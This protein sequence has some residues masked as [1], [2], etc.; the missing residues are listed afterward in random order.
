MK[1]KFRLKRNKLYIFPLSDLHLG[2]PNCDLDYFKYWCEVFEGTRTKHKII[3]L[4]GDLIDMQSLR[5]G[6]FEQNLSA[7]EQ[8]SKL[9]DLLEPY[10]KYINYMTIGNHGRRPK[11]DYNLDVGKLV[12][13]ILDVPYNKSD[14]FDELLINN[15]KFMVYGKHG[16]KFNQRLELAEGGMIR[17]TQNIVADLLMQGHNHYISYFNRPLMSEKGIKRKH[18]VFSG[19]FLEYKN[20]YA[21]ERNMAQVP[22]AFLRLGIDK[23]LNV[24]ADEYHKDI[25]F[26]EMKKKK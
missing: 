8:I 5:I 25:C 1:R 10:K 11:K 24:R 2:S 14:F 6:A 26:N 16:T 20:S 23:H 21:H 4:L 19:H 12:S 17:D 13:E 22:Q 3:Y 18:Y 7:D 9:I 15:K